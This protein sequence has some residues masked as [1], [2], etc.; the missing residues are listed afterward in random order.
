MTSEIGTKRVLRWNLE[1][2]K[3]RQRERERNKNCDRWN[4]ER[5]KER[6]KERKKESLKVIEC[7][8]MRLCERIFS[9]LLQ[10]FI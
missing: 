3:D 9:S 7:E 1:R 2:M 10:L 5:E 4:L 6:K 8:K